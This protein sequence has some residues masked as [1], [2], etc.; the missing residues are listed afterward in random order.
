MPPESPAPA[1]PSRAA[2]LPLDHF[3]EPFEQAWQTG[4][5]P[6]L[7]DFLPDEP[8]LRHAVLQELVQIDLEYRLKAGEPARVEDYLAHHP[9]LARDRGLVLRLLAAEYDLRRRRPA[10]PSLD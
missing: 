3:V 9:H 4:R 6:P 8:A 2:S 5:R 10:P 1:A 7:D